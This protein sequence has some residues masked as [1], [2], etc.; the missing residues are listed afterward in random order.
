MKG[1]RASIKKRFPVVMWD[2]IQY[3]LG[4]AQDHQIRGH[5]DF[6]GH[7]NEHYLERAVEI[8]LHLVPILG[9]R[10]V[11]HWRQPY[12]ETAEPV[13]AVFSFYKG[14]SPDHD[15]GRFLTQIIDPK[16]SP[17]I[18]VGLFRQESDTL[19]VVINHMIAD[20]AGFKDYLYLLAKTYTALISG[21][22]PYSADAG[23]NIPSRGLA[24]V[25]RGLGWRRVFKVFMA[26]MRTKQNPTG[27]IFMPTSAGNTDPRIAVLKIDGA[28]YEALKVYAEENGATLNDVFLATVYKILAEL[29]E[30]DQGRITVGI[31]VDL[32]R[33]LPK[34]TADAICNLLSVVIT[35][36][37]IAE[38][39][40]FS[41]ILE[42][43]KSCMQWYKS[44]YLG[45][46]GYTK[47]M[48]LLASVPYVW[49][50]R[51]FLRFVAN[52]Y[53]VFTNLGILDSQKLKFHDHMIEQVYLSGSVKYLPYSQLA[54]ST[55]RDSFVFTFNCDGNEQHYHAMEHFLFL[56]QELLISL[57]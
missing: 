17:Q 46:T 18:R 55:F 32:R 10:Y 4:Y 25:V 11:E 15:V 30:I 35:G 37:E 49:R 23:E 50:K 40:N 13:A 21:Q 42:R 27:Q 38:D 6:K 14:Y 41:V 22:E 20:A 39:E 28:H 7:L 2:Q 5:V 54:V 51:L 31:T 9:C 26:D 19:C 48:P 57:T 52:P 47:Y 1:Q 8:T 53:F 16:T 45:L 3:F 29:L 24:Q 44:R 12:W 36:V 33:Y 56:L 34:R 43:V